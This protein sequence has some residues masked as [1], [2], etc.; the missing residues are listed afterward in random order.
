MPADNRQTRP[1]LLADMFK[2]VAVPIHREGRP[3]IALFAFVALVLGILYSPLGWIGAAAT[4]WCIYFFRDPERVA[5]PLEGVVVSPAD[6]LVRSIVE[7]QPPAELEIGDAPMTRVSIFLNVFDVHVNRVPADGVVRRVVYRP[8]KFFNASLDK[9][10][11]DN[12]R[13]A[14]ALALGDGR[15]MA[16][17]QIAGLVARRI[18]CDL[19]EGQHVHAGDRFG[20]IRFGSRL[21]LYLPPDAGPMVFVGQRMVGGETVVA[22]LSRS[23]G[24]EDSDAA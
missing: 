24:E 16:F 8:G 6:G 17:V 22:M 5:P 21:D 11:E 12:E 7:A 2:T 1:D 18:K 10:S 9:A 15:I 14:V 3:F 23:R 4:V 13:M 19:V 20:I